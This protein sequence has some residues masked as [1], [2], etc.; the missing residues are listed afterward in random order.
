MHRLKNHLRTLLLLGA[1][2]AILPSYLWPY[3]LMGASAAPTILLGETFLVNSAAYDIRAPYSRTTIFRAASPR[4]GDIVQ[5]Y[6]PS[7]IGLGIKRVLGLPGESIEVRE[8]RVLVDGTPLPIQPL[9]HAAFNQV[10]AAHR[11]GS[12]VFLEDGHRVAYTPGKSEY[13]NSPLVHLGPGEYFLLGDNR[14]N[15]LDSRAFGP[16]SRDKI[17]GK[18]IAVR[19]AGHY[20]LHLLTPAID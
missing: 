5:A 20:R 17:V 7:H 10:F 18:V 1:G 15:S 14:D 6:L 8:N 16:V 12:D 4:R 2:L 13:R 11:M 9:D 3:S 19:P